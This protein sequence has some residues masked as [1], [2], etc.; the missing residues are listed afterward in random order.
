MAK[1]E[2]EQIEEE[3]VETKPKPK[4]KT[5]PKAKSKKSGE[6]T[7]KKENPKILKGIVE[8]LEGVIDE[9]NFIITK[10]AF[11]VEMMDPSR[12]C[13]I[14]L[15]IKSGD[16]DDYNIKEEATIGLNLKAFEKI[17]K[18]SSPKDS[19][20]LSYK[21]KEQRL[22]IKMKREGRER[23]R[24]FTLSTIDVDVENIPIDN[25]TNI[26]Y[27]S[28][29]KMDPN[30]LLEALKDAE[31]YSDVLNIKTLANEGLILSSIGELGEMTY[32]LETEELIEAELE[33]TNT[34]AYAITFLKSLLKLSSITE[35]LEISLLTDHPL[36]MVFNL[37][38]GG[39]LN[40][41]LASR[42]EEAD[43]DDSDMEEI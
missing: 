43:F 28:M 4:T 20:E 34:G 19:V 12:V 41:F 29:W 39:D 22:K 21:E 1:V 16:F 38:E 32:E 27:T 13:M 24:T 40:S 3:I 7:I 11:I 14:R 37:L 15:V 23:P 42:V 25:L 30:F 31:I 9:C 6:F 17:L 2:E 33:E 35:E 8:A 26:N 5:K 18:R 36:K 10:E